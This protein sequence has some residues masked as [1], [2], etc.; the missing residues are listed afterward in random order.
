[1]KTLYCE[2]SE[3]LE[4]LENNGIEM[5]CN[6]NMEIVISDEDAMRIATIVEDFAPFAS[7][8]YAI[9]DIAELR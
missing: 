9:E 5:I 6:E 2:N 4:I 7:G 1:M 3:L 8:D